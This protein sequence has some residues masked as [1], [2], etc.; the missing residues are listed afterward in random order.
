[1]FNSLRIFVLG[2][3]L[4]MVIAQV[5]EQE[6]TIDE[7]INEKLNTDFVKNLIQR[8]TTLQ[9]NNNQDQVSESLR[10]W[11]KTMLIE[12]SDKNPTNFQFAWSNAEEK[13]K[14]LDHD[15]NEHQQ[16]IINELEEIHNTEDP[17]GSV[18][19][20]IEKLDDMAIKAIRLTMSLYNLLKI[21]I[22]HVP[23]LNWMDALRYD[24][25]VAYEKIIRKDKPMPVITT[26]EIGR[27]TRE[28]DNMCPMDEIN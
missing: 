12:L 1:M 23:F 15:I 10:Q 4:L 5:N 2:S 13:L 27:R 21:K 22:N 25:P 26:C 14:A 19:M 20:C 7:L 24:N 6:K 17:D 11:I 8:L 18:D 16:D 9:P 3:L 28:P